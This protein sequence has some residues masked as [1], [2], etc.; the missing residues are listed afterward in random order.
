MCSGNI[1][2]KYILRGGTVTV[3]ADSS[4]LATICWTDDLTVSE[5]RSDSVLVVSAPE[6]K[7]RGAFLSRVTSVWAQLGSV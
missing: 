5:Y 7:R 2:S 4:R 3:L 6:G 1:I